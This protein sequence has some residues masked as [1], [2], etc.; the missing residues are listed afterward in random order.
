[1]R[2]WLM[3]LLMFVGAAVVSVATPAPPAAACSCAVMTMKEMADAADVVAIGTITDRAAPENATDSAADATW[4]IEVESAFKGEPS[5]TVQVLTADQGPSCGWDHVRVGERIALFS[6]IDGDAL[7]SSLCDGSQR[8]T[9]E[10]EAEMVASLG[11]P[12]PVAPSSPS[13]SPSGDVADDGDAEADD[14]G[15]LTARGIVGLVLL[16][17]AAGF[18][19]AGALRQ[20]SR[21]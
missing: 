5:S 1:M 17:A 18:L 21:S 12:T 8:L 9:P 19:V 4:T 10:L 2:S 7:R 3:V 20:R 14:E 16:V 11:E 13:P 15:G 6:R